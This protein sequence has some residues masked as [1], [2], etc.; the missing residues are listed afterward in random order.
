MPMISLTTSA[1]IAGREEAIKAGLGEAI[2]LLPGKSEAWLMISLTGGTPMY[3]QGEARQAAFVD[4]SCFGSGKPEAYDRMTGAVCA[5][6]ERELGIAPANTY[7]KYAETTN[8]GWNNK[9]F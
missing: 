4:V 8:W 9:N 3:F 6:L 2:A 7:V 1:D 5:L